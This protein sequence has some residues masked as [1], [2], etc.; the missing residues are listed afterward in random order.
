M[1]IWLLITLGRGKKF[2]PAVVPLESKKVGKKKKWKNCRNNREYHAARKKRTNFSGEVARQP[3]A[4]KEGKKGG[5][6]EE[7][8]KVAAQD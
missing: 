1:L 7:E 4:I 6:D 2:T 5:E 3:R 8:K